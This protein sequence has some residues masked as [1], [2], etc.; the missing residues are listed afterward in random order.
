MGN[1]SSGGKEIIAK[2]ER[3]INY[4]QTKLLLKEELHSITTITLQNREIFN[5]TKYP[6]M[7]KDWK[8]REFTDLVGLR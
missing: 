6:A 1:K 8:E 3:W 2:M 5:E 4:R 7:I